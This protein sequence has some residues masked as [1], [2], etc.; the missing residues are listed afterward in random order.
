MRSLHLSP[1]ASLGWNNKKNRV[2]TLRFQLCSAFFLQY[3]KTSA[4]FIRF[5][6]F[7]SHFIPRTFPPFHKNV[8]FSPSP[9]PAAMKGRT[10]KQKWSD[11]VYQCYSMT[12]SHSLDVEFDTASITHPDIK[13]PMLRPRV[14]H[15]GQSTASCVTSYCVK[16]LTESS[17]VMMLCVWRNETESRHYILYT[18]YNILWLHYD[19]P[20]I[21]LF[22][23][24]R[25]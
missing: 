24:T 10:W 1:R 12:T 7:F 19:L 20:H 8:L 14:T 18:P 11:C 17:S 6:F 16:C 5:F 23:V 15:P 2:H 9:F 22:I 25:I 13:Y 21:F 3:R 4:F